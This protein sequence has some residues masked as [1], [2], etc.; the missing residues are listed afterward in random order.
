MCDAS[1]VC[2]TTTATCPSACNAAGTDC[3]ACV[4]GE[5]MCP[6]GCKK[7]GSDIANC[8]ACGGVCADPP[9]LGSGSAVCGGGDC[10]VMC[11]VGYQQCSGNGSGYCQ[12][13][14][15]D[16]EDGTTGGFSIVGSDQMAVTSIS[17]STSVS[18]GSGSHALA[19][20]I[21]VQGAVRGFE[22]G[23]RLCGGS[24]AV[25]AS[26][27]TV[28]AWFYLSPASDSVPPPHPNSSFG[29]RLT[30][31]GNTGGNVT[32][33]STVGTWFRVSTPI[34]SVGAQLQR[35]AVV[36]TF[37]T[38]GTTDFDWSGI[39]YIDDIVIQ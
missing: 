36:G 34:D 32:T 8:G 3:N 18:H 13:Q 6:S 20:G 16:F 1:Q 29:E 38:D 11:N 21:D 17:N 14:S 39:V 12:L 9:V 33:Q 26:G 5:T 23:L 2:K 24:G 27:Q 10:N 4:A 15:W 31:S 25:P 19:I 35:I 28:S 37:E 7:L 30:A 22:V